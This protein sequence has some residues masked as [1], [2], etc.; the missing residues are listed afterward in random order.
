LKDAAKSEAT[1]AKTTTN[2]TTAQTPKGNG[3]KKEL[4]EKVGESLLKDSKL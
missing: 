4:A 3:Q 2:N 1:T